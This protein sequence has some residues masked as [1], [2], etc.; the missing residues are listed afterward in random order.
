MAT[1]VGIIF[2]GKSAEHE[3]SINSAKNIFKALDKNLFEPT[4]IGI[5]KQGSW[6]FVSS[7]D[8][9]DQ[10]KA[11]NDKDLPAGFTAAS[12]ICENGQA[13]LLK[14]KNSEKIALDVAFPILHGTYGE[15]GTIQGL[16]KMMNLAFVG[17][18]VIASCVGMDKDFMKRILRDAKLPIADF[19]LLQQG[20]ATDF[21]AIKSKLGLPFFIKPAN[22]GSSVGV[23]KIK[24]EQDFDIKL[25]DAFQFDYKVLAEKYIQGRE[26]ECSVM[27]PNL[28][29][30]AS[31]PGEVIPTHDF[32]SYEAKYLDDNGAKLKIP[33]ELSKKEIETIQKLAIETYQCLGCDGLARV[34]FFL[35]AD[36]YAIINEINTMPGFTKISMYPKMWE[37]TGIGYTNLITELIQLGI[38]KHGR[39]QKLNTNF[40]K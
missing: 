22:A 27:G 30:K 15:D 33:A 17:C 32:Y 23:H 11:I 40:M 36:G 16:F 3:V 24:S 25:K 12:L 28:N 21:S 4:L 26:I 34:D 29:P 1:K 5:S 8:S 2:G 39:D 18:D 9:F 14:I 19:M 7:G 37:A 38:Q 6:Y 35:T 10:L 20:Q 13:K 31:N